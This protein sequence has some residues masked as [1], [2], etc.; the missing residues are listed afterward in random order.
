VT[1]DAPSLLGPEE[2]LGQLK[3][4]GDATSLQAIYAGL[5]DLG[6]VPST[7]TVRKPGNKQR[8]YISWR[9]PAGPGGYVIRFEA[10]DLWFITGEPED[11]IRAASV[12]GVLTYDGRSKHNV[13][14]KITEQTV[15]VILDAARRV[16]RSPE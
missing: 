9:D 13:Q 2:M 16:K 8:R 3:A 4:R 11:L 15:P 10:R 5:V 1:E 6:Y 7:A 14:F 12:P